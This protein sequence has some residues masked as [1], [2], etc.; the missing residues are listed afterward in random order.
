MPTVY[1]V[2]GDLVGSRRA[3][4]RADL[5]AALISALDHTRETVAVVD[6]LE[7]TVGDEFQGVFATLADALRATLVVRV[8]LDGE[9]DVRCGIG[10]GEREVFAHRTPM[11]QDGPAWWAA[12]AAIDRLGQ[13]AQRARRTLYVDTAPGTARVLA[14]P[15]ADAVNAYLVVRDALL[16]RQNSRA[17]RM[18]RLALGGAS[19]REIAEAEGISPSAVSQTFARG[20]EALREGETLA[21]AAWGAA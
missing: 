11:L 13:P 14:A 8:L 15:A 12:R 3:S 20:V 2:I 5:Q 18:L 7:P 19:Q 9:G 4:S 16:D 1:A 10:A 21:A 6:R 17:R